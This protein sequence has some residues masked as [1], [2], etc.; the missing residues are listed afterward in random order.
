MWF[1]KW[2]TAWYHVSSHSQTDQ[3]EP[4]WIYSI[5]LSPTFFNFLNLCLRSSLNEFPILLKVSKEFAN[6]LNVKSIFFLLPI[7]HVSVS[8]SSIYELIDS[9]FLQFCWCIYW[10]I[11][12]TSNPSFKTVNTSFEKRPQTRTNMNLTLVVSKLYSMILFQIP[13]HALIIFRI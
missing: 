7:L 3:Y 12:C 11:Y 13:A 4:E 5:T 1:S 6:F 10:L 8:V 9:T 2:Q